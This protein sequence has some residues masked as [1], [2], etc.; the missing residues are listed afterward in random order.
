MR[1]EDKARWDEEMREESEWWDG[2]VKRLEEL[3]A[4]ESTQLKLNLEYMWANSFGEK[5]L[6]RNM[7][8]DMRVISSSWT[9]ETC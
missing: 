1:D 2:E 4:S 6:P 9:E 5:Q 8:E 3:L 7:T